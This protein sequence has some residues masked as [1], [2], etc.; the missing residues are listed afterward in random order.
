MEQSCSGNKRFF[1]E[2]YIMKIVNK[3]RAEAWEEKNNVDMY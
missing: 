1:K 2:R 3:L